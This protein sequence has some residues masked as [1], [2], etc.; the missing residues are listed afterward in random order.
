MLESEV[1][2]SQCRMDHSLTY[3][4]QVSKNSVWKPS[5]WKGD[6]WQSN[7]I[8]AVTMTK[9]LFNAPRG[10]DFCTYGH[11]LHPGAFPVHL[12]PDPSGITGHCSLQG[13]LSHSGRSLQNALACL[14]NSI[15]YLIVSKA[16]SLH[17]NKRAHQPTFR[18]FGPSPLIPITIP[19][20]MQV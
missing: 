8:Y 15:P 13:M 19:L 10:L 1:L 6:R 7:V 12:S 16:T 18:L 9:A 17:T 11:C 3:L 4:Q 14:E 5:S 20:H 2:K